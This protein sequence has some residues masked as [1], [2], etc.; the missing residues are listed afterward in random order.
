MTN[1][2]E[3]VDRAAGLLPEYKTL[4]RASLTS[5][6]SMSRSSSNLPAIQAMAAPL[7]AFCAAAMEALVVLL[8]EPARASKSASSFCS[9]VA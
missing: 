6:R 8:K 7:P 4:S 5:T 9:T 3:A 1:G 2:P